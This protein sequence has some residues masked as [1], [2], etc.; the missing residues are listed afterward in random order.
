MSKDPHSRLSKPQILSVDLPK[1]P[2]ISCHDH[3]TLRPKAFPHLQVCCG[4]ETGSGHHSGVR[5]HLMSGRQH[6][7]ERLH[8]ECLLESAGPR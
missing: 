3:T 6:R 8:L 5:A 7:A 2:L 4:N 1:G